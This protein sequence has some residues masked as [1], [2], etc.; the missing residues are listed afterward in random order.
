M[1]PTSAIALGLAFGAATD[2]GKELVS[3]V[4]KDLYEVV[5]GRIKKLYPK[6][7]LERVE[8]TPES[9]D[10]RTAVEKELRASG[11]EKDADLVA[12]QTHL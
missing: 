10:C 3:S 6:V 12:G 5:K 4:V 8:Q 7:S 9:K 11:A 1:E 2:A